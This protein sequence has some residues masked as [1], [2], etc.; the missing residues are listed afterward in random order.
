MRNT[1]SQY[2]P[3]LKDVVREDAVTERQHW[4]DIFSEMFSKPLVVTRSQTALHTGTGSFMKEP[5]HHAIVHQIFKKS[6]R[7]FMYG[8]NKDGGT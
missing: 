5:L 7:N 4:W 3:P 6:I 2:L 8:H 1:L